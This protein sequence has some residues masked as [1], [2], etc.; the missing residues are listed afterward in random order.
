MLTAPPPTVAPTRRENGSGGLR[1]IGAWRGSGSPAF[2]P[3]EIVHLAHETRQPLHV[4]RRTADGAIGLATEGIIEPESS[5]PGAYQVLGVLPALYPEWL[6]QRTFCAAHGLRF[7]YIAGEMANGIA[8]SRQVVAMARAGMLSFFG[9]AGQPPSRIESAIA[10][11]RRELSGQDNWGV[12]LIHSPG[13]PEMEERVA[14]LLLAHRVPRVSASAYMALTPAVV[15]CAAAGLIAD[16]SGAVVR[17]THLFAKVSRPEVAERFMSPAP[18]RVLRTLVERGQITQAEAELAGRIPVASDV[19]VEADSG[20]HTDNRPLVT[21]LPVIQRLR[22]DLM[23]RHRYDR[24]VRVGAA[25]GLGDPGGIAAAFGLGAAYVVTGSINQ[26]AVE[27]GVSDAAKQLLAQADVADVVMAPSADM[28]ELGVKVQVLRRGTAFAGRAGRLYEIYRRHP[29]LEALSGDER[30]SLE[31]D[32]LHTTLD[33]IEA[34]TRSFWRERDPAQLAKAERDPKQWMALVFRWYLGMSSRWAIA[35]ADDRRTDYQLWCGPAMGAFNR[36][37]SGTF[38]AEP[39]N[40]GVVQIA[41]NLLE[42]AAMITRAQQLRTFGV[43]VPDAAYRV[44]PRR[45]V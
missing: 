37:T 9:A 33:A 35:G 4:V 34:E 13:E 26:A 1:A 30:A 36:W 39:G 31:R 42:G 22:D 15:R 23:A 25:G 45:L 14:D 8:T 17:R 10:E 5:R 3:G 2:A 29:S 6:G 32:V 40:R 27:S 16:R 18:A 44:T 20:G 38:L 24:P 19:T 11:I 28:F 7:A 12:N 41:L 21:M 43:P